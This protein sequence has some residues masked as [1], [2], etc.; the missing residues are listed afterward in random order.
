VRP[1]RLLHAASALLVF[2]ALSASPPANA[3]GGGFSGYA[4]ASTGS[5]FTAGP[6]LPALLPA[7]TPFE[8]TLSL[9]VTNLGTG[10]RGF[11][12]A[13]TV[14]PGTLAVGLRPLIEVASGHRLPIPDYPLV[15][16]QKE[17]EPAKHNEQ[18][19]IS[20]A[21]DVRPDHAI[22]SA[23]DGPF[24][25]PGFVNVG[26]IHTV[27][28]TVLDAT[29]IT[30]TVTTTVNGVEV[31]V[32]H[33]DSIATTSTATSDG[34]TATCGG[35]VIVSGARVGDTAVQ[36]DDTGVHAE[37]QTLVPAADTNA[38]VGQSLS[39]SG[40]QA[41]T[42]GAGNTCNGASASRTTG[43]LLVS[44]PLPSTPPIPPGGRLNMVFG[45]TAATASA[46]TA[47][48]TAIGGH[49][50]APP[51][52]SVV[53]PHVPG[54][55]S[56]GLLSTNTA[57]PSATATM[58]ATAAVP[59][60]RADAIDYSFDGVPAPLIIGL[61]LAAIPASRRIRRYVEHLFTEVMTT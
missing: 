25:V 56:G 59:A 61:L 47:T 29:S 46:S 60:P 3:A 55:A 52:A 24:L 5:G 28:E 44:V 4:G 21:T 1:A 35:G 30:S 58:P 13:S 50:G 14:W 43:G 45:S 8:G 7:E 15:V 18:P 19:G 54:P 39:S 22:S 10:R 12:R 40:I 16:E 32:L 31:G 23:E 38:A 9:A 33:I 26:S 34:T 51:T 49:A 2:S 53:V 57:L 37:G 41:R 42:L 11:G 6:S 20:M 27:S 36:I 17:Y 48:A